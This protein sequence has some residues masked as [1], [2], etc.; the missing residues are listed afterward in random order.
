MKI[1]ATFETSDGPRIFELSGRNAWALVELVQAG[2]QG[3]TPLTHPAP[4]WSAYVF[5]LREL[6]IPVETIRE[7]HK[8]A[9]P[10]HH[11]RYVLGCD[12]SVRIVEGAAA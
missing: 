4:R 11:G 3:V 7:T 6:G 12:V 5:D 2:S 1:E 10:G 8:G 9:F